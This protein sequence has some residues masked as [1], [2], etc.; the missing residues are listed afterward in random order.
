MLKNKDATKAICG[1]LSD[2][3]KIKRNYQTRDEITDLLE[4]HNLLTRFKSYLLFVK[5][6]KRNSSGNFV[7]I[8]SK[9]K[10]N[11]LDVLSQKLLGGFIEKH[12]ISPWFIIVVK[13]KK[14]KD[15]FPEGKSDEIE[16]LY[17]RRLSGR[18][19]IKS[20][21]ENGIIRRDVG[22]LLTF[23]IEDRGYINRSSTTEITPISLKKYGL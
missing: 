16:G 13:D 9:I 19:L 23:G 14:I 18:E 11:K 20:C 15:K 12:D 3:L 21:S 2:M 6:A 4:K 10:H 1:F 7:L 17:I 8:K 5:L 22:M